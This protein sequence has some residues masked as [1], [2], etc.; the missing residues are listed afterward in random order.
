MA[1]L[2]VK[3]NPSLRKLREHPAKRKGRF[4]PM[5]HDPSHNEPPVRAEPIVLA[6]SEQTTLRS[7]AEQVDEHSG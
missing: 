6:R 2:H 3:L 1:C 7:L 4:S 5:L